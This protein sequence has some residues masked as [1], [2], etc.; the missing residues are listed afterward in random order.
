MQK[1]AYALAV[2]TGVSLLATHAL[3]QN[4]ATP[5]SPGG[6]PDTAACDTASEAT[7]AGGGTINATG[8]SGSNTQNLKVYSCNGIRLGTAIS[9]T[10]GPN[11]TTLTVS[12]DANFLNGVTSFQIS[13]KG[14]TM[15]EGQ[16]TLAM[17]DKDV[18][19]TLASQSGDAPAAK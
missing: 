3:A 1:L 9:T 18:R 19:A 5:A 6:S 7:S 8:G 17:T 13:A 11:G 15:G 12:P 4:A 10:T 14:A 2:A 16:I